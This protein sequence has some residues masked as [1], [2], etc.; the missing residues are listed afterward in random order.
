MGVDVGGSRGVR[1]VTA[2]QIRDRLTNEV[3]LGTYRTVAERYGVSVANVHRV[4]AGV[5]PPGPKLLRGM[6]LRRVATSYEPL[7][8]VK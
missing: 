6:G 2:A 1:E 5:V 7:S 8:E 3:S 4:V